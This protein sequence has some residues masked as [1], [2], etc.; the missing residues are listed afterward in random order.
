[1]LAIDVDVHLDYLDADQT[2]FGMLK[3]YNQLY[4]YMDRT[5]NQ[6]IAE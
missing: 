6:E 5:T 2:F 4:M 1:M 3:R